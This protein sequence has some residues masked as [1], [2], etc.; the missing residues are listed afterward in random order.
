MNSP[1]RGRRLQV[2]DKGTRPVEVALPELI[3]KD[4]FS[5]HLEAF[6]I[7]SKIQRVPRLGGGRVLERCGGVPVIS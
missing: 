1:V 7:P 2:P 6:P 4:V 3:R 5:G